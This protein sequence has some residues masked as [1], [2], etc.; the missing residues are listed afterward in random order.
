MIKIVLF[1]YFF[2][3][4]TTGLL[5]SGVP[6]SFCVSIFFFSKVKELVCVL[7]FTKIAEHFFKK[8]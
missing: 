2:L 7:F 3:L 4:S 1:L 6:W 8:M 5:G